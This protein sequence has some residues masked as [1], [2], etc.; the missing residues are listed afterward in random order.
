MNEHDD[1]QGCPLILSEWDWN[2]I[3]CRRYTLNIQ[4]NIPLFRRLSPGLH[5]D[6]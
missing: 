4:T 6:K 5:V 1:D 2:G 3:Y